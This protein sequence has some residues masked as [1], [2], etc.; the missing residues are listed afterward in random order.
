MPYVRDGVAVFVFGTY[1]G[2]WIVTLLMGRTFTSTALLSL[3]LLSNI[4]HYF[5]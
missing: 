3:P 2:C 4:S 1:A 5:G